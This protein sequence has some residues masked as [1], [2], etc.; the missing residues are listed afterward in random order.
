MK[1]F[2]HTQTAP[3][4]EWQVAH[5]LN[6]YPVSDIMID[7]ENGLI[8]KTLPQSL[9]YVDENNILITFSSAQTGMARLVG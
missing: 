7:G 2:I 1:P 3:A 9:E 5:N 8:E 4:L 6:C